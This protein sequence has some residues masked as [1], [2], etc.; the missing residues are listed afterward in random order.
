MSLPEGS[1]PKHVTFEFASGNK[2]LEDT[3]FRLINT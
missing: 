1:K 2:H 3:N